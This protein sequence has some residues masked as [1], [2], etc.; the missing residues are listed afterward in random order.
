MA[1]KGS[2]VP[3]C[4]A[5]SANDYDLCAKLSEGEEGKRRLREEAAY[6]KVST[7]HAE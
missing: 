4:A 6:L 3:L 5:V 7:V 1:E 2:S